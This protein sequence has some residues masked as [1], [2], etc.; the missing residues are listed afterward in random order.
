MDLQACPSQVSEETRLLR[1]PR[2]WMPS[3]VESDSILSCQGVEF[4][5]LIIFFYPRKTNILKAPQS[6]W[7]VRF[8]RGGA[9]QDSRGH[10]GTRSV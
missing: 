10:L 2:V 7:L 3:P 4:F 9:E 8:V 1:S 6:C 5:L